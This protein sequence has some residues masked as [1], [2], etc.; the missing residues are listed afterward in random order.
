MRAELIDGQV[1]GRAL[2]SSPSMLLQSSLSRFH[3]GKSD[4]TAAGDIRRLI[5]RKLFL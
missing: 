1:G 5:S 3:A 2:N 4:N